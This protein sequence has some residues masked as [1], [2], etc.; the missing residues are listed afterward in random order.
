MEI[1]LSLQNRKRFSVLAHIIIYLK[2][3]LYKKMNELN[4]MFDLLFFSFCAI[5]NISRRT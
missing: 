3:N 1:I 2:K 4:V 5:I